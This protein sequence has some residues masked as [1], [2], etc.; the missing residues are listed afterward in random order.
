MYS[1]NLLRQFQHLLL[2]Q[3]SIVTCPEM[4]TRLA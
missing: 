2:G 1:Q 3:A 4:I